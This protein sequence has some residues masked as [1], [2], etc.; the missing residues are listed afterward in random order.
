MLRQALLTGP[1]TTLSLPLDIGYAETIPAWL[2][3]AVIHRD[4]H[5]QWAGGTPRPPG[6]T[7]IVPKS[8]GGTTS[9]SNTTL[10]MQ[11]P[12]PHLHATVWRCA[13]IPKIR[14]DGL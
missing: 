3:N 14:K 1:F 7:S 2:R 4:K 10:I 11:V 8:R 9:L 13:P 12:P 5:C 6:A